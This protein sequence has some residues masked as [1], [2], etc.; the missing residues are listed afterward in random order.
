MPELPEV[1]AARMLLEA[2]CLGKAITDVITS[3]PFDSIVI[4][5]GVTAARLRSA[6]LQRTVEGVHRRGKQLWLELSGDGPCL[7][8]HFGMTGSVIVEGVPPLSYQSFKVDELQ[9]P[10]RF[11]KLELALSDGAGDDDGEGG[12]GSSNSEGG[13]RSSK[14]KEKKA[15]STSSPPSSSPAVVTRLAYCDP[16]RLGRLLLREGDPMAA[17]PLSKL[18]PDPLLAPPSAEAFRDRLLA[19]HGTTPIKATLL[20]QD[21]VRA[22]PLAQS[23]TRHRSSSSLSN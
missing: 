18:A 6:L 12:G 7:L 22:S 13:G 4:G 23:I 19:L 3:E 10:P 21:K 1:E 5:E 15:H 20:A 2:H 8:M 11:T 14:K 17:P 16:R 9:F